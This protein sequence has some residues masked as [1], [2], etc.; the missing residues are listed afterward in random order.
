MKPLYEVGQQ[1]E[2]KVV[3]V[4]DDTIFLDL[5]LKSEG[6]LNKAE[7]TDENGNSEHFSYNPFSREVTHI[8]YDGGSELYRYN[9]Q[10]VTVY[11][12][13]ADG[14]ET[15]FVGETGLISVFKGFGDPR[16]ITTG[17]ANENS[18][19]AIKL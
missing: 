5:G 9:F 12:R 10:G 14:N 17:Q 11:Q 16:S 3:A 4:T 13:D 7:L 15:D 6:I 8:T 19:K 2:T 18:F 1:I